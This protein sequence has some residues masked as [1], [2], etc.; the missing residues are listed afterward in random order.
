MPFSNEKKT[1]WNLSENIRHIDWAIGENDSQHF[2]QELRRLYP[3]IQRFGVSV[4]LLDPVR[5]GV[6]G[7][8]N[9]WYGYHLAFLE[10]LRRWIRNGQFEL[11][12]WNFDVNRENE[13]RKTFIEQHAVRKK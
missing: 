1:T 4:P 5:I 6:K 11:D 9:T 7:Y 2:E 3:A 13:K 10:V 12:Q 8:D